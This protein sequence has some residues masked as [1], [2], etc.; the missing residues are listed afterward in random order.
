MILVVSA[1]LNPNSRS[2][3]LAQAACERL[4]KS[5]R[6]YE[7]LDLEKDPLPFCDGASAYAHPTSI[8]ATELVTNASAILLAAPV[9]NFDVNAAAKNL[10]EITGRAW[11]GKVVGIM[12]AAGGQ[13]SYMSAMGLA[14][15]LM[16]DFRCVIV[17]RFVYTVGDAYE[18]QQISDENTLV[19]LDQLLEE[20]LRLSAAV[21]PPEQI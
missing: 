20:T 3:L 16:L 19:R 4:E 15:S 9:Y 2:R 12:L 11:T 10:V 21:R 14:N 17:P 5:D 7:L 8:R 18:G 1:S 13:G 6:P